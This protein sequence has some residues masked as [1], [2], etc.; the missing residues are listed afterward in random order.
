MAKKRRGRKRRL[1]YI[2]VSGNLGL[3]TLGDQSLRA[4]ALHT[5]F[6]EDFFCVY[7]KFTWG[8]EDLTLGETPITVG[9][10]HND[11]SE[12]EISEALSVEVLG[13][14]DLIE[15]ERSRRKVRQVGQFNDSSLTEQK[16][17]DGEAVYTTCKFLISDGQ[18]MSLWAL[19]QSGA[20]LTTGSR[21]RVDGMMVG[22]WLV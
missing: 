3:T 11:Y 1:V 16:I 21:I 19:N 7:T 2:P 4:G 14:E 12:L 20:T 6:T 22:R 15:T 10:A 13:P 18:A 8:L 9:L 17:G 5:A